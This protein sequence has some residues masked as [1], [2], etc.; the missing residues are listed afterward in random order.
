VSDRQIQ[1]T[2]ILVGATGVG[3]TEVGLRVARR[4]GAE[5]VSADSRL[6]YRM[7]DIGTAK[8]DSRMM[9]EIPH[10][11]VDVV[12]PDEEYTCKRFE[13]EARQTIRDIIARGRTPV[14][15]GGSGLYVRALTEG[16]FD[17]PGSDPVLRRRLIA[18]DRRSGRS[19]LWQRL[20]DVD[21][22]KAAKIDPGNL[23]RIIRALEVYELTGEPMSKLERQ[24][25]PLEV[26]FVK[27]GLTRARAELYRII[28]RRVDRMMEQGFL[29]EVKRLLDHGYGDTQPVRRSL[30]YREL[31]RSLA[32]DLTLE[33]AVELIK[34][35][36]RHFAKR[37]LTWF[38]KD[39]DISWL[40]ISGD[41]DLDTIAAV[42]VDRFLSQ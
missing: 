35:N 16:I 42:V 4:L 39:R 1:S 18:E 22:V 5:I 30:G 15:I 7:M 6:V 19:R 23:V 3:K 11:L 2:L 9:E 33:D 28:D 41:S 26:P 27:I 24:A 14:V 34:R 8:P 13:R 36:T 37:Q 40:Y 20:K 25:E 12:D 21:P 29:Y 31:I 17:G 32:G 38:R 10:H